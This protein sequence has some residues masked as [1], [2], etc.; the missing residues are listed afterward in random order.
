MA[1]WLVRAGSHGEHEQRFL[2]KNRV[3]LTWHGLKADLGKCRNKKDLMDLLQETYPDADKG[4]LKNHT[5][6]IWAFSHRLEQ[7]DWI[8]LPSKLRS[9]I[10]I[11]EITGGYSFDEGADDPY[12]HSR[13]VKW[14]QIDIPRSKFDQDILYSFGAF[15]TICRIKR[16]DAEQ[17]VRQ[18][19]KSESGAETKAA[20]AKAVAEEEDAADA[21]TADLELIANDQI[22]KLIL[23]RFKGHGMARLVAAILQA[24]GYTT[25]ISPEG[26]DKGVDILAA[27]DSLGFGHPRICVQVKSGESPLDRPTLDQLVGAM[28]HVQA[29]QGLLVSWGGFRS[30]IN[31]EEANQF[32]KV[33]LWD[34]AKLIGQLLE[35]YDELDQEIR[36]EIALKRIW[37]IVAPDEDDS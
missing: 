25:Y 34:Q 37:T 20:T 7:G 16:N 22:A 6:Q 24:Q 31:R 13:P 33:R 3:Y 18:M 5:N 11:G 30:S 29:D 12:F 35:H 28:Q 10:H 23:A 36:S 2:D 21:D 1:L 15:L 32:F 9:A 26:P 14:L 4:R 27:P 17:R 19:A 8:V